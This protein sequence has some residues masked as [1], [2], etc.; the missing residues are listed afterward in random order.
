MDVV[1]IVLE[2]VAGDGAPAE[3]PAE[4]LVQVTN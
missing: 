2:L 4:A 1:I 3:E